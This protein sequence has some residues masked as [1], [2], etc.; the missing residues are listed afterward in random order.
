MHP[1]DME[2][3]HDFAVATAGAA[4]ALAGLIIVAISV[5]LKEIIAGSGLPARAGATVAS[6][7]AILVGA[8]TM[9]IPDQP[10]L[11]LGLQ[12]IAFSAAALGFEVD[13]VRRMFATTE[14]AS[15]NSKIGT[16]VLGVGSIGLVLIG[17]V[18]VAFGSE[19]GLNVVASG[20]VA[21]FIEAILNAWVLMVEILR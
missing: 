17:G 5:N 6:I 13:A 11:L 19:A 3:W 8:A 14:G 20:F 1:L 21:I 15:L 16:A 4:A 9:L 12:L 7:T 2:G 10:A 18:M